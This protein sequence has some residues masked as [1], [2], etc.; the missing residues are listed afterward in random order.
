MGQKVHPTGFRTGIIRNWSSVWFAE[1]NYAEL[2]HED[3][4]LRDYVKKRLDHTQIARSD[5]ERGGGTAQVIMYTPR[6]GVGV[7]QGGA[8]GGQAG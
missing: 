3:L 1:K 8:G 6:R 5:I 2:L 4:K 7:V